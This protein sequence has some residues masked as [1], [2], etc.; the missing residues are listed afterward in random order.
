MK[1]R[2]L[3]TAAAEGV[4]GQFCD[5][6]RCRKARSLGGRELRTRSQAFINDE[7]LIDFPADTMCHCLKYGIDLSKLEYLLITHRHRDHLYPEDFQNRKKGF[8]AVCPVEHLHIY[9]ADAVL[10]RIR[11]RSG[12]CEECLALHE[13]KAFETF[14]VG[15]YEATALRSLHDKA[16][17][18][19]FYI[20]RKG[21]KALMYAHDTGY[22]CDETWEYLEKQE[23]SEPVAPNDGAGA[24]DAGR[25]QIHPEG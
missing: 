17:A 24:Y 3:G 19:L 13:V 15:S 1:I 6:E 4:P 14:T 9:A 25:T 18:P 22:F 12:D 21:G 8:A 10:E 23:R 2:Y 7:L 16:A 5:C 11:E 20:L